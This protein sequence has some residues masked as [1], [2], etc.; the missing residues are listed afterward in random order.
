MHTP[1]HTKKK[2]FFLLTILIVIGM[3]SLFLRVAYVDTLVRENRY[4]KISINPDSHG[5]MALAGNIVHSGQY[6]RERAASRYLSL[7]RTPGYP[8]FYAFF[9]WFGGAPVSVLWAQTV[10]G[11]AISVF[12]VLLTFML[13]RNLIASCITGLLSSVS[14]TGIF[15]TGEILADLLFALGFITAFC[16]LWWGISRLRIW[17]ILIAGLLFGGSALIKPILLFW[18]FFSILIYYCLSQARKANINGAVLVLFVMIQLVIIGG[19]SLRNY[20]TGGVFTFSTIGVQTLRHYLAVKVQVHAAAGKGSPHAEIVRAIQKQ[21]EKQNRELRA[22]LQSGESLKTIYEQQLNESLAVLS[23]NLVTTYM[24]YSQN[25]FENISRTNQWSFY[26]PNLPPQA[27]IVKLLDVLN[28]FHN[29][30][31]KI[32]YLAV[33]LA[34]CGL[35]WWR[36]LYGT[37]AFFQFHFYLF[38]ALVL[39]CFYFALLSGITF[40]TGPRIFY[41]PEFALFILLIIIGRCFCYWISAGFDVPF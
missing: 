13:F 20:Y 23:S 34:L 3:F 17:A 36:R 39:T 33:L 8:L 10:I 29:F 22:A 24:C 1:G 21:K 9:E 16:L 27:F 30:L 35:P 31:L 15:L 19:W 38:S 2:K 14:T 4:K 7:I 6:A 32:V 11:A 37:D 5:Y 41:P 25:I 26:A 40:W 12:V 28:A 18:P